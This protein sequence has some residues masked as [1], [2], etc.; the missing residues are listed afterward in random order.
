MLAARWGILCT[1]NLKAFDDG[2]RTE[3]PPQAM[4]NCGKSNFKSTLNLVL[5]KNFVDEAK[6]KT[7]IMRKFFNVHFSSSIYSVEQSKRFEYFFSSNVPRFLLHRMNVG[8]LRFC[9][10]LRNVY[11]CPWWIIQEEKSREKW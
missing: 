10:P 2:N 11:I 7:R 1:F 3:K 8:I 6:I 4:F 5:E 9:L